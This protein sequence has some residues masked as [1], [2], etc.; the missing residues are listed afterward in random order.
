MKKKLQAFKVGDSIVVKPGTKDPNTGDDLS[1][2]QG[3]IK[4]YAIRFANR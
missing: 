3:R 2:R 4:D 1:G